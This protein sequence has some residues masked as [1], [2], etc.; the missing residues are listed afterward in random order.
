LLATAGAIIT[1]IETEIAGQLG[2]DT[3]ARLRAILDELAV[4]TARLGTNR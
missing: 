4:I 3:H 2:P 1:E